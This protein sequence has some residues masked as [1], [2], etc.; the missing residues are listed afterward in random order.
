M[1]QSY[2]YL[3]SFFPLI[4]ASL[5]LPSMEIRQPP[6]SDYYAA[7]AKLFVL[8]LLV[9]VNGQRKV[10]ICFIIDFFV[11]YA[12]WREFTHNIS[13]LQ[14]LPNHKS[15]QDFSSPLPYTYVKKELLPSSFSWGNVNGTNYLTRSLNQHLPQVRIVCFII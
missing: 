12:V 4:R 11:Q 10:N 5:F 9:Q 14:I 8:L 13:S 7:V 1:K 15:L 6:R 3:Y 2:H